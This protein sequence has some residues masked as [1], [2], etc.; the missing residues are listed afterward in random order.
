MAISQNVLSASRVATTW[1]G[2]AFEAAVS[3]TIP[4]GTSVLNVRLVG[5]HS[6]IPPSLVSWNG[7]ALASRISGDDG[8]HRGIVIY[9]LDSPATTTANLS[10]STISEITYVVIATVLSGVDVG[11]TPRGTAITAGDWST[12]ASV[13]AATVA[14]DV[15][16]DVV[17]SR[18]AT[19]TVGAGQT[20]QYNSDGPDAAGEDYVGASYKTASGTT[21]SMEWTLDTDQRWVMAAIPYKPAAEGGGG[22]VAKSVPWFFLNQ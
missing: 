3:L 4:A 10:I 6:R 7:S 13:N 19:L 16:L 21:T 8:D 20:S 22:S 9:D 2:S 14:G 18:R 17:S 12:S 5:E 15:V 11:G 1:N